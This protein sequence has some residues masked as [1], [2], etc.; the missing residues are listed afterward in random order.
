MHR[1]IIG[2]SFLIVSLLCNACSMT[3]ES[4]S[5]LPPGS[6]ALIYLHGIDSVLP[7]DQ[8][9]TN[10][11]II[12]SVTAPLNIHV[13]YLRSQWTCEKQE[14]LCW[15]LSGK[16]RSLAVKALRDKAKELRELG[17]KQVGALGF[18]RGGFFLSSAFF[19]AE[20]AY[21]DFIVV[22]GAG[23]DSVPIKLP[24]ISSKPEI[25]VLLGLKD[26]YHFE[27]TGRLINLLEQRHIKY[28]FNQHALGHMLEEETLRIA[29]FSHI[30]MPRQ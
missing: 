29:L 5:T 21:L 28:N 12:S 24:S 23:L 11:A 26:Q 18:S 27:A 8:E 30:G 3:Q 22:S 6:S 17:Y 7:S 16:N 4:Q 13:N 10:R 1:K 9:L 15:P 25:T 20:L 2:V 19:R 14:G